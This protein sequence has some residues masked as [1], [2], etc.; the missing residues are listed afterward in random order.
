M[1]GVAAHGT[2]VEWL[3]QAIKQ[4]IKGNH[5][6]N[7]PPSSP[8]EVLAE[9]EEQERRDALRLPVRSNAILEDSACE[10]IFTLLCTA[11]PIS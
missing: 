9:G 7:I 8:E 1:D 2:G 5:L 6:T 3:T 10:Q 11:Q 4:V